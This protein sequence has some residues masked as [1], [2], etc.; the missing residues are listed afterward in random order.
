MDP[1]DEGKY[2]L[3][4]NIYS[5]HPNPQ[6]SE[7]F[8]PVLGRGHRAKQTDR[9]TNSIVFEREMDANKKREK[10]TRKPRQ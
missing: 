1:P 5:A 2:C 8:T 9:F 7:G 4:Y 6:L 3:A 10:K